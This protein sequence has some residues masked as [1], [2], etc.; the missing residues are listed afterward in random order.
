MLSNAAGDKSAK[1][2]KILKNVTAL[3]DERRV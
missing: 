1:L 2:K 3:L